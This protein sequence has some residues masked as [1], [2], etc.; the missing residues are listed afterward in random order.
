MFGIPW[1]GIRNI[2]GSVLRPV[3]FKLFISPLLENSIGPTYANVS[4]HMAI[5]ESNKDTI[6]TL[7]MGINDSESWLLGSG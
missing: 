2:Q 1:L 3:L 4:Y 6:R 5:R 7:Q